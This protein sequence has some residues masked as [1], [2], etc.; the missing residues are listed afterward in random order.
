MEQLK[1]VQTADRSAPAPHPALGDDTVAREITAVARR[2][3]QSRDLQARTTSRTEARPAAIPRL[4]L[5][6]AHS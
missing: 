6:S 3:Q 4:G 5:C 2:R 1:K